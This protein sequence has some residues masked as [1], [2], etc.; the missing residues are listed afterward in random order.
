[1]PRLRVHCFNRHG[2]P[3][4]YV[5]FEGKKAALADKLAATWTGCPAV[6][7]EMNDKFGGIQRAMLFRFDPPI[8]LAL[9]GLTWNDVANIA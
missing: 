7:E 3:R 1:M 8:D 2:H 5:R 6:H 4:I 9:I